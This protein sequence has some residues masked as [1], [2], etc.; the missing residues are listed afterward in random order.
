[1]GGA[2]YDVLA[3]GLM[4]DSLTKNPQTTFFKG[5]Y[6]RHTAFAIESVHQPF[7]TTT[8]Y[9]SESQ[10]LLNRNGDALYFQYLHLKLPGIVACDARIERGEAC[11]GLVGGGQFPTYFDDNAACAPCAREDERALLEYLPLNFADL[12]PDEKDEAIKD[13]KDMWQREKYG[14]GRE[15][16]C[17]TDSSGDC[18]TDACGAELGDTWAH[19]CNDIGHFAVKQAKLVIGGVEVDKL[20]GTFMFAYEELAGR[21]GRRLVE[22]TGRRY[23]RPALVCDSREERDLYVPMPWWYTLAS[24]SVLPLCSLAYHGVQINVEFESLSKLVVVS[25]SHVI[26][27][28]ARTGLALTA[29]DL[30]ASM[31]S[32]YVHFTQAERDIFQEKQ[33]AQL[34]VQTQHYFQTD[35]K[36]VCRVNLSFNH[37]V[38]EIIF[39]IRRQCMERTNNWGNLSGVGGRDALESAELLLN[40]SSRFGK[41]PA[42]YW[43]SVVP[44]QHHSNIPEAYLYNMCFALNPED[45][46]QPSGSCNLSRIDGCELVLTLQS[47]LAN[48]PY[49]V[50]VFAR[51]WNI[52]T[53][54]EGVGGLKFA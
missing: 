13:A 31:E 10:I 2:Y 11:A 33:F 8:S 6:K 17:C 47:A 46:T 44:Y 18:P 35:S 39:G 54:K 24:G 25:G 20:W 41:K 4:D 7:N 42:P 21:S 52:L 1:M 50:F 38:S 27:R 15:L 37:P 53:Y 28:N 49:T 40:N 45:T 51:N 48:E 36:A 22:M 9:G 32:T 16:G 19:F 5:T 26:V 14:A 23:T 43:R 12:G 30:D 34:I 3:T 29:N